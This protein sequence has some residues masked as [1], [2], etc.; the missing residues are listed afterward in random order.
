MAE[1]LTG[2]VL[3][4]NDS[5]QTMLARMMGVIGDFPDRMMAEGRDVPKYFNSK[6]T[7]FERTEHGDGYVYVCSLS[8][9]SVDVERCGCHSVMASWFPPSPAQLV[10]PQEVIAPAAFEGRGCRLPVLCGGV[11]AA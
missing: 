10:A 5:V 3:F 9:Q 7:V 4:Q 2:K 8:V 11:L 1:L 6:G